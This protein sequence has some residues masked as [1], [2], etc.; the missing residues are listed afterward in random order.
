MPNFSNLFQIQH[1]KLMSQEKVNKFFQMFIEGCLKWAAVTN[2]NNLTHEDDC[3]L[4]HVYPKCCNA[5]RV[6]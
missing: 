6:R 4:Q 3:L 5:F 2:F 1:I